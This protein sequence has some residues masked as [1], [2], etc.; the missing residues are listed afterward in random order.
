MCRR[1]VP[2]M[3][4]TLFLLGLGMMVLAVV[5]G[6]LAF[7]LELVFSI[8]W[9]PVK[10]VGWVLGG[11]LTLLGGLL[12]V[13]LLPLGLLAALVAAVAAI[14]FNP[15]VWLLVLGGIA[16]YAHRQYHEVREEAPPP[17][18]SPVQIPSA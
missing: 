15:L 10:A 14:V 17:G 16:W 3:F 2:D 12:A 4:E 9:L 7:A 11:F 8:L 6:A 13:V 18:G 5:G 1:G